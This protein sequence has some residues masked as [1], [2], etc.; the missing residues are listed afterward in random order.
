MQRRQHEH[1]WILHQAALV[2]GADACAARRGD[3]CA[4]AK[5]R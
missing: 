2:L 1:R 4:H 5:L 3:S